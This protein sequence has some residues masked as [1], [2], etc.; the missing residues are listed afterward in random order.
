MTKLMQIQ[1]FRED[2]YYTVVICRRFKG[3]STIRATSQME[4]LHLSGHLDHQM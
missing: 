3:S 4:Q 1:G 2:R